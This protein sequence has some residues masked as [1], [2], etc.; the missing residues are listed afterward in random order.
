MYILSMFPY[1]SGKLHP[2]HMRN[3]AISDVL[4]R[5]YRA[6]GY[7]VLHP[8]GWDAFGLPAEN[9][10][11][12]HGVHPRVWTEQNIA[13]MKRQMKCFDF[14]FDWDREVSTADP[15]YYIHTQKVFIELYK[16]GLVEKR[17]AEVNWDPIEQTVL[18]NEQVIDGK[19]WRSGAEIEKRMMPHWFFKIS[20]LALDL[21]KSLDVL[22]WPEHVK[23]MQREW[24]KPSKGLVIKFVTEDNQHILLAFSSR[25]ETIY[26]CKFCV[27][28]LNHP[29][30]EVMGLKFTEEC[31]SG[32]MLKHPVTQELV[33]LYVSDYVTKDYGTGIVFGCPAHDER[34]RKLAER[35]N[36]GIVDVIQDGVMINSGVLNGLTIENARTK[37]I[38]QALQDGWGQEKTYI[39]L[40][41]W[42]ISRQRYWGCPIPIIYC[43]RCGPVCVE[44]G[45]ILPDKIDDNWIN[46]RC[47]R[48]GDVARREPDT[49]DTFVDSSW[50][51]LRFCNPNSL[52]PIDSQAIRKWMPVS[53]Y[54]GGIE[55]AI[56]HLL[57][58]RFIS[59]ALGY[60]EP[61]RCLFTQGMVLHA[62]Y[63][64]QDGNWCYPSNDPSLTIGPAEKMSKS[65]KNIV[66]LDVLLERY[67]SDVVRLFV[68]SDTPPEKE[69]LWTEG[70]LYGCWKF[71]NRLEKL[72][73]LVLREESA[74]Q[75][76]Q[77]IQTQINIEILALTEAL[78]TKKFNLYIAHLHK[79]FN[80]LKEYPN[81][82]VWLDFIRLAMPI[83]PSWA[84]KTWVRYSQIP[85][86][87]AG[88]PK[89][90]EAITQK[91][92]NLIFQVNGR[93]Q[94]IWEIPKFWSEEEI[95]TALETQEFYQKY[96]SKSHRLYVIPGRAVNVVVNTD[97]E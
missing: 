90:K 40:R 1:P 47:P 66:P 12:E 44:D 30:L 32:I 33:P 22:D 60:E 29:W 19:G 26:G 11:I 68:L 72:D 69:L 24:I 92:C 34:D 41:D 67:G 17:N 61:F 49:M 31:N 78:E 62:T 82:P 53:I 4:A 9:A 94:A 18:A 38:E 97:S 52:E 95:R 6:Q 42:G 23:T 48:C 86:S 21:H 45:V 74:R 70:G 65:K 96:K 75:I 55:H 37:I 73:E 91:T 56:L 25:P 63:N 81:L 2:G 71:I 80:L 5:F 14:D 15:S 76:P 57:Y 50:Y 20:S 88:W 8:I 79:I 84:K 87:Q 64:D 85:I 28:A 35:F 59:R 13:N 7:E 93:K 16:K 58:A 83:I 27:I 46:T 36:I 3:Y 51:F 43:D 10:A 89:P 77:A 54:I 39:R